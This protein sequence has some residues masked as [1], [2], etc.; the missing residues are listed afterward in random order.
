V[1]RSTTMILVPGRFAI[2]IT[3]LLVLLSVVVLADGE[4]AQPL[5]TQDISRLVIILVSV[6]LSLFPD[7]FGYGSMNEVRPSVHPI[8]RRRR[9]VVDIFRELGPSYSKRA[10]RMSEESFFKLHRMLEGHLKGTIARNNGKCN[11]QRGSPNG[12][13]TSTA[14]LSIAIRYFAG[15]RP[16]DIA[17]VHGVSHSEVF[18]SV[19]R[20]VDAI[21]TCD[22]LSFAFPTDH[23]EQYAIAAGF[24]KRSQPGFSSCCGAIDGMLLW[25]ERYSEQECAKA[26]CGPKKFFCGRKHKFGLNMQGTC[27]SECR[28]LDVCIQ[29]PASTSDF[30]AFTTSS[31]YRRL[32]KENFLAP[33]L[34]IFGDSAYMNCRYFAT[35]YKSVSSGTKDDYNFYHSQLRIKIE[36]AFGQLVARWGVLRRA[37]PSNLGIKK[38]TSLV[39]CLCRLHNYCINERLAHDA[40]QATVIDIPEALAADRLEILQ[41]GGVDLQRTSDNDMSPEELLHGGEHHEDT[42]LAFRR[43]FVKRGMNK[44]DVLPRERLHDIVA[45]G[46]FT[47]PTPKKW[48]R[49]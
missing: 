48:Q 3:A 10:Y 20:T 42:S 2:T 35:P 21:L 11:W 25:T 36:C 26:G 38:T 13:I 4:E 40:R 8:Q 18:K 27:D 15:G 7:E 34:C 32:E 1:E 30:L 49:A 39:I 14:R 6:L 41:N 43:Q 19:W 31:L 23:S 45:N 47:R 17:L 29:H 12:I 44:N 16:E 24:R 37:I 46:G 22:K 33:G 9:N 28:F 5:P